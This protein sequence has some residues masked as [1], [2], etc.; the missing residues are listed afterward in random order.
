MSNLK[1]PCKGCEDRFVGCHQ[2][3]EKYISWKAKY[4]ER[5]AQIRKQKEIDSRLS[6]HFDNSRDKAI[7]NN[8]RC[9]HKRRGCV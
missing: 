8:G 1:N 7:R 3:C 5:T 9:R 2:R 6:E 4:D